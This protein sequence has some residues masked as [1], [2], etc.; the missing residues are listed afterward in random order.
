LPRSRTRSDGSSCA[1]SF[2]PRCLRVWTW[3][4]P[5]PSRLPHSSIALA[6]SVDGH[7]RRAIEADLAPKMSALV[8][9]VLFFKPRHYPTT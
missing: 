7:L 1:N 8:T 2:S 3:P 6:R 4:R 5:T 9:M